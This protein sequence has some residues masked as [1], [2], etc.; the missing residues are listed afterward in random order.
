MG[1]H[2][3]SKLIKDILVPFIIVLLL[4]YLKKKSENYSIHK[5]FFET[6]KTEFGIA[7]DQFLLTQSL[8]TSR[9]Q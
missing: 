3:F 5:L 6:L 4:T 9:I 2:L 8:L 1:L 7:I